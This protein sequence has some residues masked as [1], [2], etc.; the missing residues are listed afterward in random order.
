[1]QRHPL[2]LPAI[3]FIA[4]IA[5]ATCRT[6]PDAPRHEWCAPRDGLDNARAVF[7]ATGRGR[8]AFLGGSITHNAGWRDQVCAWLQQ[9]WPDVAFDFVNAGIPSMG[10]PPGAFR[11]ER[12][13]FARGKVDL[14]F[15]EAAVNDST[16]G[17]SDREQI[18]AMEGI[19]RHART[20]NPA[21]DIVL[22]HFADPDKLSDYERGGTPTVIANHERVAAHYRLPSLDLAREVHDRIRRGEFTWAADF[23]DLHPS[24]FGQRLYATSI[25]RM[26]EAAWS[27]E[28]SRAPSDH[29]PLPMPLD[30][31]CYD[32]GR[33]LTPSAALPG[34]GFALVERWQNTV[35]GGTRTGFVDVPMLVG[36]RPSATFTLTFRGRAVGLFV[37]A[38][39]DAGTLEFRIDG[40][41]WRNVDLFTR[42]SAEL[43]LPWLHVLDA[44]LDPAREHHLVVRIADARHRM[45]RGHACRIAHFVINDP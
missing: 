7:A 15:E 2:S 36:E 3:F 28:D 9:R 4:C 40:G 45:S 8:V 33:L 24:P 6:G 1:M 22:L 41:A 27:A 25:V 10:S 29:A 30:A 43:H 26:L 42:W 44:E 13:V 32:R 21:I 12:D 16:N 35:G 11:I 5:T 18:R 38:G 17:H 39:P 34:D 14:L 20:H 23:V 19:V 37:A 31:W